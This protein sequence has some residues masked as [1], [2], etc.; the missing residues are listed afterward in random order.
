MGSLTLEALLTKGQERL[1][2]EAMDPAA[3]PCRAFTPRRR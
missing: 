1:V 2:G 3:L